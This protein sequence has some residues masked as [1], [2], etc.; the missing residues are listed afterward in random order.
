M[1]E[2]FPRAAQIKK[3]SPESFAC[4][5]RGRVADEQT[6][7]KSASS[8]AT[9]VLNP[10]QWRPMST[11]QAA[12]GYTDWAGGRRYSCR[13][14]MLNSV[15]RTEHHRQSCRSERR[16]DCRRA[17]RNVLRSLTLHRTDRTPLPVV[18]Q[19]T[20]SHLSGMCFPMLLHPFRVEL[21]DRVVDIFHFLALH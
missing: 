1:D 15:T 12:M 3:P 19:C 13:K 5:A 16:R 7:G 4:I 17:G 20:P 18:E 10:L 11:E 21:A 14:T 6:N 2:I 9:R 8:P